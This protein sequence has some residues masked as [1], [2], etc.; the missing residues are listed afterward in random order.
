MN[1]NKVNT[2]LKRD[3]VVQIITGKDKGK[4]GKVLEIN[5][6]K[7][8]VIVEGCNMVKKTIKRRSEQEPGRI[9]DTEAPSA[10]LQ[11]YVLGQ[12]ETQ[13]S[14]IQNGEREESSSGETKWG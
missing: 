3:D 10:H 4:T 8:R 2:K 11:R 14:W 1:A 9:I 5:Y 13:S 6:E 7:G 12:G